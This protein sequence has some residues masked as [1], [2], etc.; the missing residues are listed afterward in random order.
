MGSIAS[1]SLRSGIVFSPSIVLIRY[2][3]HEAWKQGV[4]SRALFKYKME[5]KGKIL[6]EVGTLMK[7][8]K[9]LRF[10]STVCYF[11]R[12]FSTATD[13]M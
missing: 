11:R 12:S 13:L 3:E 8:K 4:S 2:S 5:E 1:Q 6:I 10:F 7:R 9:V